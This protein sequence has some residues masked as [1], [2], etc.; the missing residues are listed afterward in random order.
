MNTAVLESFKRVGLTEKIG[1]KQFYYS[2][3]TFL[4]ELL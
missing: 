2:V 1:Q 4:R 3:D